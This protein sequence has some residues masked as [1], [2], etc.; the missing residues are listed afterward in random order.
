MT[1]ITQLEVVFITVIID[2][3]LGQEVREVWLKIYRGEV[4]SHFGRRRNEKI[5]G[6][7]MVGRK[8]RFFA[9]SGYVVKGGL[10]V[11]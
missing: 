8:C 2:Y 5:V 10:R 3:S 7:V 11:F 9:D 4:F 6:Q 1:N